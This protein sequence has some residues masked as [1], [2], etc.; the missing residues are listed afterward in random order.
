MTWQIMMTQHSVSILFKTEAP[1]IPPQQFSTPIHMTTNNQGFHLMKV[2][3]TRVLTERGSTGCLLGP[4]YILPA[5][6]LTTWTMSCLI[7]SLRSI[8][9]FKRRILAACCF[10]IH[11]WDQY[12]LSNSEFKSSNKPC[13][14]LLHS[15]P[16]FSS[17]SKTAEVIWNREERFSAR[18][19]DF[20]MQTFGQH[21]MIGQIATCSR[22]KQ[23][24]V[25][26]SRRW[27]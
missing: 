16:H 12:F 10:F 27:G 18:S 14:L 22:T 20:P 9:K 4:G 13:I 24:Q 11:H 5:S 1:V 15:H 2:K 6:S 19:F 26:F 21:R 3:K 23:T 17:C 8:K 7:H 25:C